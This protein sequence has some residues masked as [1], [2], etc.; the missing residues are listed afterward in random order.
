MKR[1]STFR[2]LPALR[3]IGVYFVLGHLLGIALRLFAADAAKVVA[4]NPWTLFSE[5]SM[6]WA[7][8]RRPETAML[9]VR[10]QEWKGCLWD[11]ACMV[12]DLT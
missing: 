2:A 9:A 3:S 6:S 1:R 5:C 11:S 4:G 7:R 12:H 8:S 10:I